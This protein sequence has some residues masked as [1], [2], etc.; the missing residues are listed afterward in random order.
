MNLMQLE[1][2]VLV[3]A[4]N[5]RASFD[6]NE[7]KRI[8]TNEIKTFKVLINKN[9]KWIKE[10]KETYIAALLS[11]IHYKNSPAVNL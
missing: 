9:H 7:K 3:R 1:K 10:N 6:P 5:H 2:S 8:K 4:T 11:K